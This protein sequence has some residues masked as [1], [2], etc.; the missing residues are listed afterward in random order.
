MPAA[1]KWSNSPALTPRMKARSFSGDVV[2][3]APAGSSLSRSLTVPS[4]AAAM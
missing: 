2:T 3:I 4:S 1:T